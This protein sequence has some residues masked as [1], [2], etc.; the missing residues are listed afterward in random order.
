[1][2]KLLSQIVSAI[3]GLWI[4]TLL[5]LGVVVRAYSDSN[6]FGLQVTDQWQMFLIIG[7]LLGSIFYFLKPCL[8]TFNFPF[9]IITLSLFTIAFEGAFLWLIDQIFSELYV[10]WFLPLLYTTLIIW[11]INLIIT[12]ILIRNEY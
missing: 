6:F 2:K 10:P 9:E 4:A 8:R 7:I 3:G 5:P 1:M 12:K 11:G